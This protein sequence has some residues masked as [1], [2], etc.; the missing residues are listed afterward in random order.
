MRQETLMVVSLKL[1][2]RAKQAGVLHPKAVTL[3]GAKAIAPG[4][5]N[6]L[7]SSSSPCVAK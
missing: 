7:T 4:I 1:R 2:I 6:L 3:P 5:P